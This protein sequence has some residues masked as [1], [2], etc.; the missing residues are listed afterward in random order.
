M[1]IQK[2]RIKVLFIKKKFIMLMI[3]NI[4]L[5]VMATT[6]IRSVSFAPE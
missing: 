1:I 3:T 2:G 4:K 5:P 6:K